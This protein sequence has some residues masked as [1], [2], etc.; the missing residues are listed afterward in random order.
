MLFRFAQDKLCLVD[1]P[2]EDSADCR[3]PNAKKMCPPPTMMLE[4]VH[5]LLKTDQQFY[6]NLWNWSPLIDELSNGKQHSAYK[7]FASK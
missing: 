1:C 7:W 2:F 5:A 4:S 3:P 6:S